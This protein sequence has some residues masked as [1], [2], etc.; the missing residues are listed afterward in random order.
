MDWF[1]P[2]FS[3][4]LVFWEHA[5]EIYLGSCHP[6]FLKEVSE[7][8]FHPFTKGK[9]TAWVMMKS[10]AFH[11]RSFHSSILPKRS[12]SPNAERFTFS[13]ESCWTQKS[14]GPSVG[15]QLW[16][17]ERKAGVGAMRDYSSDLPLDVWAQ[18]PPPFVFSNVGGPFTYLLLS[19]IT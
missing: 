6:F 3:S 14:I 13:L 2:F 15:H 11:I 19:R 12:D 7:K 16:C 5:D 18:S 10:F 17:A 1:F 4:T 8:M 9:G